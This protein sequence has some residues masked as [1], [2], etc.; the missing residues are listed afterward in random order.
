MGI[1]IFRPLQWGEYLLMRDV[2]KGR[3]P[4]F[5]RGKRTRGVICSLTA[6][7]K[8]DGGASY[9]RTWEDWVIL[10]GSFLEHK[11]SGIS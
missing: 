6:I 11:T 2:S 7:M 4:G 1:V 8:K 10:C 9:L 3:R 5:Y